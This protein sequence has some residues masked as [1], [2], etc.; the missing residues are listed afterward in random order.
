MNRI[1]VRVQLHSDNRMFVL[2]TVEAMNHNSVCVCVCV[3]DSLC[4]IK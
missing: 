3:C 1:L 2:E 4:M